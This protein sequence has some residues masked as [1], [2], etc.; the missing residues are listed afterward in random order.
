MI[1]FEAKNTT[2]AD[3]LFHSDK[4]KTYR[5]PRFQRSYDWKEDQVTELW[6]DMLEADTSHFIGSFIFNNEHLESENTIE[7][8]DG[9]QR[10]LTITILCAALRNIAKQYNIEAAEDIQNRTIAITDW[11]RTVLSYRIVC[12]E[13]TQKFFKEY[14]QH[15]DLK[16]NK[17]KPQAETPEEKR[18]SSNYEN[19]YNSI[20]KD[21]ESRATDSGKIERL[22]ELCDMVGRLAVIRME[23][24]SEEDAY[25]IFETTNARGLE[26]SVGDLVKNL[27]FQRIRIKDELDK[28]VAKDTWGLITENIL[29]TNTEL[30]RFLRYYWISKYKF[31][32]EKKLFRSIKHE[33]PNWNVFL[34][35]LWSASEHYN[36]L[37]AGTEAAWQKE[38]M[39]NGQ[40]IHKSLD[41]IKLM[42][43]SQC[44]VLFLSILR[45]YEKLGTSTVRIFQ[46]IEKF[47]FNYSVVCK[48]PGN[49]LEKLY[50]K[51]A[52]RL[53][54]AAADDSEKNRK[55]NIDRI[56]TSL[57]TELKELK[58]GYEF[59]KES[60]RENIFYRKSEDR[61]L[62]ISYIL[63]EIN[64][65]DEAGEYKIDFRNVN[66]EHLL[67]QNPCD[68]WGLK[69]SDIKPYV[70]KLGNL[71][72]LLRTLNSK[73]ANKTIK[74][75]I[76]DLEAA[77]AEG[78]LKLPITLKII[79]RLKDLNF[80]WDKEEILKRHDEL[81]NIAY[82]KAWNF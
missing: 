9:Q 11:K 74:D 57:I 52:L 55:K 12:G 81:A 37:V 16:S 71:T 75:K 28:D 82:H 80:K 56:F 41:A 24:D 66:I 43:V 76:S 36:M 67:P 63:R 70:N 26:L 20:F 65:L 68:E 38:Y 62:L 78:D 14:I 59:F 13:S 29:G 77:A 1:R 2:I 61:V 18:I 64:Q 60:F 49:K 51:Y 35:D 69:K 34:D 27:I 10:L 42:N 30:K 8:I 40:L 73:V 23:I 46:L 54:E 3:I 7:I 17:E 44:Y 21:I 58:P 45:N 25:E 39:K 79:D 31:L 48:L 53:Q 33:V 50:S 4:K 22:I 6:N 19:L 72:L 32:S 5:I 47:S 15:F